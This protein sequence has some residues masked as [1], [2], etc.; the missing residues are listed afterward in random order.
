MMTILGCKNCNKK[1]FPLGETTVNVVHKTTKF[2]GSCTHAHTNEDN[3][4]F[5]SD[6]CFKEYY[7]KQHTD[8]LERLLNPSDL[9]HAVTAEVRDCARVLLG[10]KRVET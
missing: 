2:C 6:R 9:G 4:F 1:H 8:F 10:N 3:V 5:C 7:N